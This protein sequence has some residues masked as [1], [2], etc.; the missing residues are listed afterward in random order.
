MWAYPIY[1]V[2]RQPCGTYSYFDIYIIIYY[3]LL[4][5]F[6]S[7]SI[8]LR[9]AQK[10]AGTFLFKVNACFSYKQRNIKPKILKKI[11][12][13][14][15]G[16]VVGTFIFSIKQRFSLSSILYIFFNGVKCFI[17]NNVLGHIKC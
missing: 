8:C 1:S 10:Y 12:F 5:E 15:T 4:A 11:F 13:L 16:F 14:D 2:N 17:F 9:N 3:M 6:A 7:K